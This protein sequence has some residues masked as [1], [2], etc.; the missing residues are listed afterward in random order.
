M[1]SHICDIV[2]GDWQFDHLVSASIVSDI[3]TL[4][5]TCILTL[6]KRYVWSNKFVF[7]GDDPI[8]KRG[9]KVVIRLGY[10][11]ELKTR[12]IG[13]IKDIEA[14]V[15]V[16][17]HCEDSMFLLKKGSISEAYADVSLKQLL[18]DILPAGIE[19]R[20]PDDKDIQLGQLRLN[21][22][23]PARVMRELRETY[24]LYTYFQNLAFKD[25][26]VRPVLLVGLAYW[27]DIRSEEEFEFGRNI[28]SSE[29]VYRRKDDI[30]L[31]LK[32]ISWQRDNSRKIFEIG[33]DDGEVR[34]VHYYNL[35]KLQC[36][37]RAKADLERYKYTGYHGTFQ[38]FGIPEVEK[39][40]V[41]SLVGNQYHPDGKYLIKSVKID[42]G[43]N[44]Y[45]QTI[46]PDAI[47]N[48]RTNSQ[49]TG[50][51]RDGVV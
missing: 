9:D 24:G 51:R 37:I 48:D 33:D 13:Y 26:T 17:I 10:N 18:E 31:K 21:R 46:E 32:V 12:F 8:I 41:A 16:K 34:T 35:S 29:L 7:L 38:T 36:E 44:G 6:P 27:V 40:D 28:I 3:E 19:Y 2:I 20:T 23:S 4:T 42:F 11:G 45:Q 43:V 5:D 1:V 30:R 14:G 15:P 50:A 22:A 25:G 39:G 49:A 47:I